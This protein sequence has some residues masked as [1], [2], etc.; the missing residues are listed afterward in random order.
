MEKRL[1]VTFSP[2]QLDIQIKDLDQFVQV[3]KND[4][5]EVPKV[6]EKPK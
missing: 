1:G 5:V 4:K 2:E 6:V 3:H